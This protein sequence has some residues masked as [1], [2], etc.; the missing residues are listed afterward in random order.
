MSSPLYAVYFMKF[1]QKASNLCINI[2]NEFFSKLIKET[3]RFQRVYDVPHILVKLL[4]LFVLT[5]THV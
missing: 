2:S 3:F 4:A 5:P 1:N